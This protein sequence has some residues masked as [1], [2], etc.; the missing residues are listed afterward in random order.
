MENAIDFSTIS[1]IRVN[2][3]DINNLYV[4]GELLWLKHTTGFYYL[5]QTIYYNGGPVVLDQLNSNLNIRGSKSNGTKVTL[6]VQTDR[7]D[8]DF[9]S[10]GNS[11]D[12]QIG[13]YIWVDEL[14]AQITGIIGTQIYYEYLTGA[15]GNTDSAIATNV[16]TGGGAT[17]GGGTTGT[18]TTF[19]VGQDVW[20][21]GRSAVIQGQ[22]DDTIFI[23]FNDNDS[24]GSAVKTDT[25]TLGVTANATGYSVGDDIFINGRQAEVTGVAGNI[26]TYKFADN[27][28]GSTESLSSVGRRTLSVVGNSSGYSINESIFVNGQPATIIGIS[29]TELSYELNDG[30]ITTVDTTNDISVSASENTSGY[31]VGDIF[32]LNGVRCEVSGVTGALLT[33]TDYLGNVVTIN[34]TTT[35]GISLVPSN[36]TNYTTGQTI[37][38]GGVPKIIYSIEGNLI[39]F[40]SGDSIDHSTAT[41][42]SPYAPNTTSYTGLGIV[43]YLNGTPSTVEY[44]DGDEIGF[45]GGATATDG[46]VSLSTTATSINGTAVQVGTEVWDGTNLKTIATIGGGLITFSDATQKA[47]GYE[48][49]SLTKPNYTGFSIG[50]DVYVGVNLLTISDILGHLLTFTDGS[51][52]DVT[53]TAPT[54][55]PPN[56]TAYH[57]GLQIYVGVALKTITSI[58]GWV[59]TFGDNSTSDASTATNLS[60]TP[61]NQTSFSVNDSVYYGTAVKV[62]ASILGTTLTFADGVTADVSDVSVN[63]P[64]D[65]SYEVGQDAYVNGIL[66]SISSIL[67]TQLTFA[68]GQVLESS[69]GSIA[70]SAKYLGGLTSQPIYAG[71][72]VG[73]N[74]GSS[75]T[76]V[77]ISSILNNGTMTFTPSVSGIGESNWSTN[78]KFIWIDPANITQAVTDGDTMYVNGSAKIISLID[79]NTIH[80][81]DS[82]V[83]L[84]SDSS[85]SLTANTTGYSV[86]D[87]LYVG[88]I[89]GEVTAVQGSVVHYSLEDDSVGS[90]NP[91]TSPST[92]AENIVIPLVFDLFWDD[93]VYGV[94][95]PAVISV[96]VDLVGG[97]SANTF[98]PLTFVLQSTSWPFNTPATTTSTTSHFRAQTS[99][100]ASTN[101]QVRIK[102]TPDFRYK[103]QSWTGSST[104]T[105]TDSSS[106]DT[107]I[108]FTA[109]GTDATRVITLAVEPALTKLEVGSETAV[110]GVFVSDKF[111]D[112]YEAWTNDKADA[113][114]T[115][116]Y[117]STQRGGFILENT[118]RDMSTISRVRRFWTDEDFETSYTY[119]GYDQNFTKVALDPNGRFLTASHLQKSGDPMEWNVILQ[120]VDSDTREIL[121]EF[122]DIE[123]GKTKIASGS[124]ILANGDREDIVWIAW[125]QTTTGGGSDPGINIARLHSVNGAQFSL[126]GNVLPLN[127]TSHGISYSW[128]SLLKQNLS[129]CDMTCSDDGSKMVIGSK[130][131]GVLV[132]TKGPGYSA[133]YFGLLTT[134]PAQ[135]NGNASNP[136]VAISGNGNYIAVGV[137]DKITGQ[138][139]DGK[140]LSGEVLIY[141]STGNSITLD[142]TVKHPDDGMS[143]KVSGGF[144]DSVSLS[145]DGK[146]LAVGS[147]TAQIDVGG[148]WIF[149]RTGT[150][151]SSSWTQ[152]Y[153]RYGSYGDEG[154]GVVKIS[155]CGRYV[156][157]GAIEYETA[158]G[159][160]YNGGRLELW[161]FNGSNADSSWNMTKLWTKRADAGSAWR[162]GRRWSIDMSSNAMHCSIHFPR[163]PR[164]VGQAEA[165]LGDI[166]SSPDGN[167]VFGHT[168][169]YWTNIA[170]VTKL[171]GPI[172]FTL[173]VGATYVA[174]N[175][176]TTVENLALA[177]K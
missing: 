24:F 158:T 166:Y 139:A 148:W 63:P 29:G 99:Y 111:D 93:N 119:G 19:S 77:T 52:T 56:Y 38:V 76:K 173:P 7:G 51:Q 35:T 125:G 165:E 82:I 92:F 164:T 37:Y 109:S 88:G 117:I 21:N 72:V 16:A 28:Y 60:T 5:G 75:T 40:S 174:G 81:T 175:L 132:F 62:I 89:S 34:P 50:D 23:Q 105:I 10:S 170:K 177:N 22:D 32:Y 172:Y 127:N 134:I 140:N 171:E 122:T 84:S 146:T 97:A 154:Y 100:I 95:R 53:T 78:T 13:Q 49:L 110:G 120:L 3:T 123:E 114:T 1:R 104:V 153:G 4:D 42:I 85:L 115:T 161:Q 2:G 147:T 74:D 169:V 138:T 30:T 48:W 137:P 68:N 94:D 61:P 9:S 150:A 143:S 87:S 86:G 167:I 26:V 54:T 14:Q 90:G 160:S 69:L 135:P 103:F 133:P 36:E 58:M 162:G 64:N 126:D 27:T 41:N 66:T 15:L 124:R 25:I 108:S 73:Y 101:S 168:D 79:G 128:N 152:R 80:F 6:Q 176:N 91:T 149:Q 157:V 8:I 43:L 31:N 112:V 163:A 144:G 71:L 129:L 142:G 57:T 159:A 107:I 11:S 156:A 65:T 33:Y 39:T 70:S 113:T 121:Q 44:Y 116:G 145:Y 130:Y 45:V 118:G 47:I 55:G 46:D 67:G 106:S 83:V 155:G 98:T 59:L 141:Y 102:A 136:Q 20:I 12:Y 151:L 131:H 17:T 18:E 96:G